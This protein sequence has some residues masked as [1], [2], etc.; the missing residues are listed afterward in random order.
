[1]LFFI[2]EAVMRFVNISTLLALAACNIGTEEVQES[3]PELR[4]FENCSEAQDFFSDVML[5]TALVACMW[6]RLC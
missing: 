6:Q 1:M 3:S 2:M 4:Q 5:N